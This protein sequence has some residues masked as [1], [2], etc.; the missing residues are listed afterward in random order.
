MSHLKDDTAESKRSAY[1][2]K[3]AVTD[4]PINELAARRW[5]PRAFDEKA[6]EP[7][8]IASLLEAARWAPSSFNEQPW[9]YLVFDGSDPDALERARGCLVPFNAW[10]KKA[11]VLMLSV[12]G[13]IFTHNGT[14]NRHAQHD[15]GLAT[16]NMVLEAVNQGLAVHQMAGFDAARARR[17]FGIPDKWTPMAMIAIGYPYTGS[18]DA[19]PAALRSM[20]LQK[21]ERKPVPEIA[22]SGKWG[23]KYEKR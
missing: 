12:A 19:L 3:L 11:P 1:P 13:E 7:Q 17:E 22:F 5:S 2:E 20:E 8:K 9:R 14:P 4:N 18:L 6:V 23:A 16:A 10:A 21:R 15:V